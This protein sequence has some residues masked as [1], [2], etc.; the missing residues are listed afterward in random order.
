MSVSIAQHVAGSFGMSVNPHLKNDIN[1]RKEFSKIDWTFDTGGATN[2]DS[3][4]GRGWDY[5]LNKN[6][7]ENA[8]KGTNFETQWENAL[9]SEKPIDEVFI[10]GWNE[11]VAYKLPMYTLHG[12]SENERTVYGQYENQVTFCD[13]VDEEFSRDLEMTKDGYGNNFYLQNMRLTREF[14]FLNRTVKYAGQYATQNLKNC[15]WQNARTYLDF[16]DEVFARDFDRADHQE[17]Y[18]NNTNRNDI[19]STKMSHDDQHLYMQIKTK[20]ALVFETDQHNNLNVLLKIKDAE[21][22]AWEGY[23]YVINR[24]PL[25]TPSGRTSLEAIALDGIFTF[26][27]A[28]EVCDYHFDNNVLSIAIPLSA[29][30]ISAGEKFTIDFKVADGISDPSAIMNYYIDGDSAPIG[31]LNYRYN[32]E[33]YKD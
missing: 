9:R 17:R 33:Y 27:E 18:Y 13:T 1:A 14:K 25:T 32:S 6:V 8:F 22:P 2:Y 23:H 12:Q 3:N 21:Q 15:D 29:L 31:R 28:Q 16:T 30:G 19:V 20:D 10:T 7:K 11:W 4:R 26:E 5:Q 24:K